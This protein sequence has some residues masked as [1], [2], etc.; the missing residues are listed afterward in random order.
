M[1]TWPDTRIIDL[2][3]IELPIIQAPMAVGTTTAMVIEASKAGALGSLPAAALSLAQLREALVTVREAS[4]R[5]IN[6]NFF[7]HQPPAPDAARDRHWKDLLEPYYRELGADFEAPTPVSNRE[8]FNEAACQFIEELRPEV[9]SFHFGLPE[10]AL[11]DR[12]K[13][14]GA[15]VL[16]SATTVEE[17]IWLEQHG[18]DAIIAMGSEAGGH[19]GL[20]LSDDLNTQIG[21]FALLPQVV[22]A[23]SV[24]VIAAGGIGDARGIVAAFALGASA[25]QIGTAYLFT[26]EANVTP[27][28]HH[29]LRH[30]QA[31]ETA[32]TNLF[33]GRPA[34]G[35]VNRVMRELGPIN[36]A[37]PAF[38]TA[39]GALIPLKAKDEAG[40][41]NLWSGQ[42]LRLGRDTTTYALTRELAEQALAKITS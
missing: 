15:K 18:C 32:L 11:L 8:P 29:A 28:H 33:T 9:V 31:S 35:I 34:R 25:V 10:K 20:F 13:A 22:D 6:V 37:A 27:S 12:V 36:P 2:L 30:A 42:A 23:V 39:G 16:S 19:R 4:P 3:G 17:A 14:T 41:S 38:P 21:L 7:C 26:P 24:P 40:F 1:S 5:P